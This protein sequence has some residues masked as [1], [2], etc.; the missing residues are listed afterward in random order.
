MFLLKWL[1]IFWLSGSIFWGILFFGIWFCML[2][3]DWRWYLFGEPPKWVVGFAKEYEKEFG[4]KFKISK[5]RESKDQVWFKSEPIVPIGVRES[6][7]ENGK[8]CRT[9]G[10]DGSTSSVPKEKNILLSMFGLAVMLLIYSWLT[11]LK[12]SYSVC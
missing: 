8:K 1:G 12:M 6:I 2:I 5:I 9:S 10:G 11:P 3:Y 7:D 4:V